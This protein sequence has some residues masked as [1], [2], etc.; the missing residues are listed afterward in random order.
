MAY[1]ITEVLRVR[2]EDV[3]AC[4]EAGQP[5]TILDARGPGAWDSSNMKIPGAIRVQA[6]HFRADP[7]WPRDQMTVVY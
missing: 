5:L 2:P 3:K 7:H 1:T 4:L 6:D